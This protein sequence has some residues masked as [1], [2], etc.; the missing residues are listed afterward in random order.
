MLRTLA[1]LVVVSLVAGGAASQKSS[2]QQTASKTPPGEMKASRY[3]SADVAAG[4]KLFT[5][6]CLTCHG[7][8]GEGNGPASAA[9]KPKPRNFHNAKDFKSKN[10][11]DLF[12]V[13]SNGGPAMGL[14]PMMVG[15]KTTLKEPQIRQLIA[16]VRS[17]AASD[18]SRAPSEATSSDEKKPDAKK[19][20]NEKR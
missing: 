7:K 18:T 9:L 14:S 20:A 3:D 8:N 6:Y 10:D 11:D 15:W 5:K 12:K 17:F 13:I 16:Y 4:A 2:T 1:I 19:D